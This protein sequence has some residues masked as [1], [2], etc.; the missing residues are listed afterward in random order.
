[1][2]LLGAKLHTASLD[3]QRREGRVLIRRLNRNEYQNTLHDLLG[4]TADLKSL[5]PD[6]NTVAGFDNISTGLE[7]SATHLVRYQA[8]A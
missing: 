3:K 4:I 7:T 8:A 5:L 2:K 6:D 1:M